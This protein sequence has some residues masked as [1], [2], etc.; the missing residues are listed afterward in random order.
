MSTVTALKKK[1][2]PEEGEFD[3]TAVLAGATAPKA[4]KS[5]K[6]T[7][8][9]L[10]VGEDVKKLATRIREVK[11]K[12]DSS[13]SE[14]EILGAELIGKVAPMRDDLCKK[15][16]Q[17][18][19]RV[20]DS[21]G[22]SVGISWADKYC[23]IPSENED[24]LRDLAGEAYDDYF[25]GSIEVSVRDISEESLTELVKAVGPERFARFFSVTKTIKPTTRFTQEQFNVYTPEQRQAF[26]AAGVKQFKPS[27][28][29]K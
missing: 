13:E 17:S 16:Y 7:V 21:K 26:I 11:E 5:K 18:S 28:K 6:S 20:P 29:V 14:Y 23:A 8:P 1:V 12:L 24:A 4:S 27:I 22:L 2:K 19:V 3:L 10:V 25:T 9:V 15:S